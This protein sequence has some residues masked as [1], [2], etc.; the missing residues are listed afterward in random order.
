MTKQKFKNCK[1]KRH[2]VT[3]V[4]EFKAKKK[5]Q[6]I[7]TPQKNG[8]VEKLI[9]NQDI[10]Q[11]VYERV[12]QQ[13][14]E[15]AAKNRLNDFIESKIPSYARGADKA[16]YVGDLN[17]VAGVEQKLGMKITMCYP[18]VTQSNPNGWIVGF[19]RENEAFSVAPDFASEASTRAL[20]ILVFLGV[21]FKMKKMKRK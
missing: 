18:A 20:A 14:E 1:M 17:V 3:N 2:G 15:A 4:L 19:H 13:W 7:T 10:A 6:G 11:D 8:T 5:S 16:D 21:E 12:M 9:T